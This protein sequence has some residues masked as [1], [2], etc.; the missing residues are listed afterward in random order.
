MT[1][2]ITT[3]LRYC[4]V[5][6]RFFFYAGFWRGT[7][8]LSALRSLLS[9]PVD[10]RCRVKNLRGAWVRGRLNSQLSEAP[11]V[12]S[13]YFTFLTIKRPDCWCLFS[14]STFAREDE[15]RERVPHAWAFSDENYLKSIFGPASY[16][17]VILKTTPYWSVRTMCNFRLLTLEQK[18]KIIFATWVRT[19]KFQI[20]I[21][22]HGDS[23]ALLLHPLL[24]FERIR[25]LF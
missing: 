12:L 10:L 25:P 1:Q 2:N 23:L 7:K 20:I 9:L 14:F 3:E 18:R 8:P 4:L 15:V 17:V 11:K 6:R 22:G 5:P 13:L 16:C 24:T 19:N 21:M